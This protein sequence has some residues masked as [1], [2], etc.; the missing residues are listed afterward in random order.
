MGL[1]SLV[2]WGPRMCR[3]EV[4]DGR[5]VGRG[6]CWHVKVKRSKEWV[7]DS[8]TMVQR[9]SA[10]FPGTRFGARGVGKEIESFSVNKWE[11][12]LYTRSVTMFRKKNVP[13]PVRVLLGADR[14][15]CMYW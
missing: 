3:G 1:L 14:Q 2:K 8:W 9:G 11:G 5:A 13:S 12:L 4:Q 15:T 7:Q 6:A 10:M